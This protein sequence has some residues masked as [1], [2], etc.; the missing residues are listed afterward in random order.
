MNAFLLE[1]NL[2]TFIIYINDSYQDSHHLN[3]QIKEERFE[4]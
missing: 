4:L 2:L 1:V 3:F